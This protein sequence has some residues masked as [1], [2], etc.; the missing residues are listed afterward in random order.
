LELGSAVCFEISCDIYFSRHDHLSFLL[1][2][3]WPLCAT[4]IS[5][6]L[7]GLYIAGNSISNSCYWWSSI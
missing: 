5:W 2:C 6:W 4:C 1:Q 3:H 7:S